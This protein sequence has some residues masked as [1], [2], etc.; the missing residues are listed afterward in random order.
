MHYIKHEKELEP[1]EFGDIECEC[2][3]IYNIA[4]DEVCPVCALMGEPVMG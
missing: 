1:D 3:T 4:V 2:G